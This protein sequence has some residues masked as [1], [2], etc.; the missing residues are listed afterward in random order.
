MKALLKEKKKAFISGDREELKRVQRELKL[1]IRK[2][3]QL[4]EEAGAM[5]RT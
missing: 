3:R 5:P 2:S 4:Q 1:T